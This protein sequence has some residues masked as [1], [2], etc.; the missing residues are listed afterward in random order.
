MNPLVKRTAA[1]QA[2]VDRYNGRAFAWGRADCVRLAAYAL[3]KMG[4]P[5]SLIKAG[6]YSSL[7]GALK[8]LR[9]AGFDGL[10]QAV[11]AQGLFRIPPAMALP[12]DL[13]GLPS[14]EDG[15]ERGSWVALTV[16]LGNGRVIGFQSGAAKI[17]QPIYGADAIAWRVEPCLR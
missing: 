6:D 4:R 8:A 2:V 16:A 13:I 10:E 1:A 11:D 14:D 12:G 9:R 3:R 15:G 5:V 7:R 17:L